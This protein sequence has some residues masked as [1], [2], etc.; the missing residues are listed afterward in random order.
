M[1]LM[2]LGRRLLLRTPPPPTAAAAPASLTATATTASRGGASRALSSVLPRTA[3]AGGSSSSSSSNPR[4]SGSSGSSS[5]SRRQAVVAMSSSAGGPG[6]GG[7][8]LGG[9]STSGS[10][11]GGL[12]G[13]VARA[14]EKAM[15]AMGS[16]IDGSAADKA[17]AR[18]GGAA[19]SAAEGA[20]EAAQA[21]LKDTMKAALKEA[22]AESAGDAAR[23]VRDQAAALG[24]SVAA[25]LGHPPAPEPHPLPPDVKMTSYARFPDTGTLPPTQNGGGGGGGGRPPGLTRN[26]WAQQDSVRRAYAPLTGGGGDVKCEVLVV[27]GGMV[28]L[29]VAY[30]LAKEGRDVVVVE[31]RAVGAGQSGRTS[32]HI[33]QWNDDYYGTIE[34]KFGGPGASRLVA[35]SHLAAIDFIERVVQEEG[36]DCDFTRL[37]GYLF[38]HDNRPS[39]LAMLDSELAA[40]RRAGL[41][42]VRRVDLAGLPGH[43]RLGPALEFPRSAEFHPLKYLHGL[44]A[45]LTSPKYGVRLYE[46][47]RVADTL[48]PQISGRVTTDTGAAITPSAA[49]VYATNSPV[50]RNVAV[51]ARQ[52]ANRTYMLGLQVPQGSLARANWWSTEEAYHYVRLQP[53]DADGTAPYD[54]L[55][56]GGEDHQTGEYADKYSDRWAAL[57]AFARERWPQAGEVLYRWSGQVYEPIDLLGLYG[58]DPVNPVNALSGCKRYIATGDSGQGMTGSAIAAMVL[59]DLIAGRPNPWS[60]LYS[61]SRVTPALNVSS[62]EELGS[63]AAATARGLVDTVLPRSGLGLAGHYQAEQLRPG[64]GAVLQ[65][66]AHKV[67][68]FRT[69]EGQLVKRS[70]ICPHLGCQ[71]EWNPNDATFDCVCHGSQFDAW[72]NCING[73]ANSNLKELF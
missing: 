48:D 9:S 65:E 26:V 43:G 71:V 64:E 19:H 42:D 57:E 52:A 50:S 58:L 54:V 7:G 59:A 49:I 41:G 70:S 15:G 68:A 34:E 67:A 35:D 47:T 30:R 17:A 10:G 18:L 37:P 12:A 11:G 23:A 25:A 51:H 66:G 32:A 21:P 33:M 61:P 45:V 44:A 13:G 38:P 14:A 16:V 8:E 53:G 55:L 36:I 40:C 73:P 4:S 63:E 46:G 29:N 72:G 62:L 20:A 60:E 56:I 22:G 69:P 2:R 1:L 31:A 24:T 6:S 28:G 27:G 5:C 39:T 3:T